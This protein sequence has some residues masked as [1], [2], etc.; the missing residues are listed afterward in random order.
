V[1]FSPYYVDY[2]DEQRDS[3]LQEKHVEVDSTVLVAS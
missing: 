2:G 3:D 1:S